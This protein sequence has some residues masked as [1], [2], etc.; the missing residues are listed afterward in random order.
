MFFIM[1]AFAALPDFKGTVYR[2]Y[3]NKA[4]ARAPRLF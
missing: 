3:P 2:G 1:A 4:Q